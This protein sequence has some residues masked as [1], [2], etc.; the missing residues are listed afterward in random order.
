MPDGGQGREGGE[1]DDD[2]DDDDDDEEGSGEDHTFSSIQSNVASSSSLTHAPA[3][4]YE[5]DFAYAPPPLPP[6]HYA[7][8]NDMLAASSLPPLS[9][10]M[11]EDASSLGP[12]M[13]YPMPE[14]SSAFGRP[15]PLQHYGVPSYGPWQKP[16]PPPSGPLP[17]RTSMSYGSMLP[18]MPDSVPGGTTLLDSSVPGSSHFTFSNPQT[19]DYIADYDW[20]FDGT[21]PLV[22]GKAMDEL[23]SEA[24]TAHAV[25]LADDSN[26]PLR[27]LASSNGGTGGT[28]EA[29]LASEDEDNDWQV[30]EAGALHDLAFFAILQRVSEG[31]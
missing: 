2:E 25:H 8:V 26:E 7:E 4:R 1:E 13:P 5:H 27:P 24:S 22:S 15:P 10:P 21:N 18:V 28:A 12:P 6:T 23:T 9:L 14:H 3:E 16:F 17:R 31:R 30:G 29:N 19:G 20:L 11:R